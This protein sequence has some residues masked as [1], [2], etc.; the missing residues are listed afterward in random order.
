MYPTDHSVGQKREE[1]YDNP[2][3]FALGM[4]DSGGSSLSFGK[5]RVNHPDLVLIRYVSGSE[6][7]TVPLHCSEVMKRKTSSV[8]YIEDCFKIGV[9]KPHRIF[10]HH[11]HL[12]L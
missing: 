12:D 10:L 5:E 7:L 11:I 9:I 4:Y 3:A 2:I 6:L 8:Y 1:I